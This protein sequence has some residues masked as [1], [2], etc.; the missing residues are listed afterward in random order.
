MPLLVITERYNA[1]RARHARRYKDRRL[2]R[3]DF[4][5]ISDDCWGGKI[6]SAFGLKCH[7][8]FI[9]MGF[10]A[11]EYL[12]FVCHFHDEGALDVLGTSTREDNGFHQIE[13]R[14]AQLQGMH[15]DSQEEFLHAYE[16]R[17][18]T[19]LWDRVFIKIDF[20]KKNYTA[21]D[22]ARWNAL[23]FPNSI[24]LYPDLPRFREVPI[25][26]GVAL[27]GWD[28]DGANQ[29]HVSCRSFDLFEWLNHGTIRWSFSYW[30]RQVI[31]MEKV[32]VKRFL[33]MLGVGRIRYPW[34]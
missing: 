1:F 26:N 6:Y 4:T 9:G 25:H 27:P 8:P 22:I 19:I 30:F 12:D 7:S 21:E 29:F 34:H 33:L 18:K 3:Q 28:L 17:R 20:G 24:A 31:F 23:K 11:K 5:V 16:R 32:P 10:R 15:Y 13:T 14:H 2:I